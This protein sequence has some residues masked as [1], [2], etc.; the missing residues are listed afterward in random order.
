MHWFA[1]SFKFV[2]PWSNPKS[3]KINELAIKGGCQWQIRHHFIVIEN[4]FQAWCS[5]SQHLSYVIQAQCLSLVEGWHFGAPGT[6]STL[7]CSNTSLDCS[8]SKSHRMTNTQ[9]GL[10][11]HVFRYPHTFTVWVPSNS[12]QHIW[13]LNHFILICRKAFRRYEI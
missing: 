5:Q 10:Y 1:E 4:S 3:I 8:P 6:T 12:L 11:R 13:L 7:T 9:V 2:H